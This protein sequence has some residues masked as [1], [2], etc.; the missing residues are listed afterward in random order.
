MHSTPIADEIAPRD[1]EFVISKTKASAFFQ[2]A[3]TIYLVR[4]QVDSLIIMGT[5]TSG[6][7]APPRS[8]A[9]RTVPTFLVSDG[10]FDRSQFFHDV[11]L[12]D[13]NTKYATIVTVADTIEHLQT[14][15]RQSGRIT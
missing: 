5:A 15:R 1:G 7:C 9:F 3:L 12:Y 6:A 10:C 2:T 14:R 11:T 8:T 13:L 4:H